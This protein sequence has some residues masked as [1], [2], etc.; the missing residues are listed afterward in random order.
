[1]PTNGEYLKITYP[2]SYYKNK[3][4]NNKIKKNRKKRKIAKRSRKRNR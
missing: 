1:M 2:G 3:E 4:W